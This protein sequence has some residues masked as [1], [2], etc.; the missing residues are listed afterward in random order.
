[1][2]TAYLNFLILLIGIS[3]SSSYLHAANDPPAGDVSA[4][5]KENDTDTNANN[6]NSTPYPDSTSTTPLGI[7]SITT[8]YPD[9]TVTTPSTMQALTNAQSQYAL[10]QATNSA[11]NQRVAMGSTMQASVTQTPQLPKLP[12]FIQNMPQP[13]TAKNADGTLRLPELNLNKTQPNNNATI[14]NPNPTSQ[15]PAEKCQVV[16][17]QYSNYIYAILITNIVQSTSE[18]SK[19]M[20]KQVSDFTNGKINNSAQCS[21]ENLT[22]QLSGKNMSYAQTR[23][24]PGMPKP[25][26]FYSVCKKQ[27]LSGKDGIIFQKENPVIAKLL[28]NYDVKYGKK[29]DKALEFVSA[30]TDGGFE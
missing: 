9:S 30:N 2:R 24:F 7:Q 1:M 5:E 13:V 28:I 3:I 22:P 27:C 23:Y 10:M 14:E 25:Q 26:L 12:S 20:V 8:P 11:L 19:I 17:G 18:F 29:E 6:T 15:F 4:L 16:C 21:I